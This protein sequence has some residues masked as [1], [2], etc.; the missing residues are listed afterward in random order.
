[1]IPMVFKNEALLAP[2]RRYSL[3]QTPR[4]LYSCRT[5]NLKLVAF[6]T[7]RFEVKVD[8]PI[9][10]CRSNGLFVLKGSKF[11]IYHGA[12]AI[13]PAA[14]KVEAIAAIFVRPNNQIGFG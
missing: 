14:T 10:K 1:M 3:L 12:F 9:F 6:F 4:P 2:E 11:K 7:A 8:E 5:S 13:R